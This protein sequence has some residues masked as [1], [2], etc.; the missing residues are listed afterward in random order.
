MEAAALLKQW[1]DEQH[2]N[3]NVVVLGDMNDE[4]TDKKEE[5]VFQIFLDDKEN[6]RF[7]D[8]TIALKKNKKYWSY[9]SYPSHIDHILIT[10]ELFDNEENTYTYTFQ[11]CDNKYDNIISDHHPVCLVLK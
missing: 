5:N 2:P 11:E 3:D 7:A 8:R 6:Y 10:N 9:P 1:I 4:I